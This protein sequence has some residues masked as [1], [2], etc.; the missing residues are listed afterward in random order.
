MPDSNESPILVVGAG[1]VGLTAAWALAR[2]GARVRLI[3]RAHDRCDTSRALVLWS[4]TLEVLD[5]LD[6]RGGAAPFLAAGHRV[7]G[8]T[9]RTQGHAEDLARIEFDRIE[10][11]FRFATIL[12]QSEVERLLQESLASHGVVVERGVELLGLD[13]RDDGVEV[14]LRLPGGDEETVVTPWLVAC[15]GAHSPVR[16]GLAMSFPGESERNDWWL[17]DVDVE[18]TLEP[19]RA[20]LC[21]HPAGFLG[22]FP[23][24]PPLFRVVAALGPSED[25]GEVED[26]RIDEVR[27]VVAE[28]AGE[29]LRVSDPRWISGFRVQER[30]VETYRPARRVF[31][32]GDAAHVHGPAGGQGMNTG[33]QDACNLAWKLALVARGRGHEEPLL[34]SYDVERRPVGAE[35]IEHSGVLERMANLPGAFGRT[36]RDQVVSIVGGLAPI[37]S[38]AV[39][40][41]AG[42]GISYPQSP[43]SGEHRGAMAWVMGG[44]ESGARLPDATLVDLGSE[45]GTDPGERL[46]LLD[47]FR[48]GRALL[49]LFA[50]ELPGEDV[51]T[52]LD[53]IAASIRAR[54]GD[55]VES[56]LVAPSPLDDSAPATLRN[57]AP[58]APRRLGD[59]SGLLHLAVGAGAPTILLARPDGHLGFRAQPADGGPLAE[60]L[61]RLL[62]DAGVG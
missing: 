49:F 38:R 40:V 4:R 20:T 23:I 19:D 27:L 24:A 13:A 56:F 36:I 53:A 22:L 29:G 33:M 15:D 7:N 54:H 47:L 30:L 2:H 52:H 34:S 39:E 62:T 12:P 43:L 18:G 1:P 60:Y 6:D 42:T 32:A 17:A 21:L 9:I 59:P 25:E 46:Q 55:A 3:D 8:V 58:G 28:R 61:D 44:L 31:L 50:A 26:P 11:R 35:A 14:R 45:T 51:V 16:H 5:A 37:Q 41:L 10:S 48:T 57:S